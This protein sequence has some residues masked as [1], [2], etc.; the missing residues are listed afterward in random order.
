MHTIA[1]ARFA[2]FARFALFAASPLLVAAPA[3][4]AA[5]AAPKLT[6]AQSAELKARAAEVRAHL[7]TGRRA[8]Q[9]KDFAAGLRAFQAALAL[10]PGSA[11]VLGE[12][13]WAAFQQ[14]NMAEAEK[15]ARHAA[16]LT[17]DPKTAGAVL[18]TLGRALE[19]RGDKTAAAETYRRSLT[20]RANKTVEARLLALGVGG[21]SALVPAACR[22]ERFDGPLPANVCAAFVTRGKYRVED[23]TEGETPPASCDGVGAAPAALTVSGWQVQPF[24]FFAPS[25]YGGGYESL[26]LAVGGPGAW[27]TT[28]LASAW[29]PGMG[30][31]DGHVLAYPP[32]ARAD[33]PAGPPQVLVRFESHRTDRDLGSNS[34]E[35][36]GY[37]GLGIV[38][39]APEGPRWLGA[40]VTKAESGVSQVLDD[41]EEPKVEPRSATREIGAAPA[42]GLDALQVI[43]KIGAPLL[44]PGRRVFGALPAPCAAELGFTSA[45]LQ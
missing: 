30:G 16:A 17:A 28:P 33:A 38:S 36:D 34:M 25:E 21:P 24:A 35:Y 40:L 3:F 19:A 23:G 41:P 22:F 7:N 5:P 43:P 37:W 10:D 18:Y 27:Y 39:L 31:V 1:R 2:R 4:A 6:A 42:P 11:A 8:V 14:G 20:L 26:M 12:L 9:A 13:A 44:P 29:M 32:E 15:Q 45:G